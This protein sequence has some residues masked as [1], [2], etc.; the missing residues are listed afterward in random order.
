[1]ALIPDDI[2]KPNPNPYST[3]NKAVAKTGDE[4]VS[5]SPLSFMITL[6]TPNPARL[7]GSV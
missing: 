3:P 2:N 4:Y 1:M 5:P 6:N 7:R